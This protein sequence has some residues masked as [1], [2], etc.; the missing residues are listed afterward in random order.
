[1]AAK[2]KQQGTTGAA[3]VTATSPSEAARETKGK[4][5]PTRAFPEGFYWGT[6]TAAY[7]IEGA[8]N[9]D[10]KGPSIWD[11]FTQ[12][13]GKVAGD[14]SGNRGVEHYYR[15]REDVALMRELGIE[16]YRFSLSWSRL[17]PEGTGRVNRAGIDF[18]SRLIDE[19]LRVYRTAH[20]RRPS[21][22]CLDRP[23]GAEP[24]ASPVMEWDPVCGM[25]IVPQAAAA[26]RTVEGVRY[27]FCSTRCVERFDAEPWKY[28][29]MGKQCP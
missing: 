15:F 14:V 13:P 8:W 27:L 7:Q 26:E 5:L 3:A 1:M 4:T 19:L 18:Y 11:T 20:F 28:T 17:M 6:A 21:C 22:F 9:E 25:E 16:S 29:V 23:P 12:T 2:T 10:G 24:P